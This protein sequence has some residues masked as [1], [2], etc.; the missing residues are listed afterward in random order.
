MARAAWWGGPDDTEPLNVNWFDVAEG[1]EEAGA[2]LL[3][4]AP[5]QVELEMS[6]P[7]GART[8][9]CAPRP[10]PASPPYGTPDRASGGT[11]PVPVDPGVRAAR[12][13]GRLEFRSE[14][15]D[16]VFRDALRRIRSVALDAHALRAIEEGGLD[17][18]AQ[19]EL[20]SSTGARRPGVV[21]D[22]AVA[23]GRPGRHPHPA[24]NPSGPCVGSSES[25]PTNGARLAYDLLAECTHFLVERGAELVSAATDRGTSRWREL[26]KAGYPVVRER[27][28]FH[29]EHTAGRAAPALTGGS[30]R[31]SVPGGILIGRPGR[32]P[33][34]SGVVEQCLGRRQ[35]LV[36]PQTESGVAPVRAA[37]AG[38]V[39][40]V[41]GPGDGRSQP[42]GALRKGTHPRLAPAPPRRRLPRAVP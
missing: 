25:C 41:R 30:V 39:A 22:R 35:D 31:L 10:R 3:R 20:T 23:A 6:L 11:L 24:H 14:P 12:A 34:G 2:E 40:G 7:A 16:G 29:L 27:L 17:R 5:W 21:A 26:A 28:N 36:T 42:L 32:P 38:G 15:D 18:A 19:E 8:R 33:P 37:R 13:A 9:P 1:E 4:T